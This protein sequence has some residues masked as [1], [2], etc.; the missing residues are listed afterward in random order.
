MR[1]QHFEQMGN[2]LTPSTK[3]SLRMRL[4]PVIDSTRLTLQIFGELQ[5]KEVGDETL[6][7][8][9]QQLAN[10]KGLKAACFRTQAQGAQPQ[11]AQQRGAP[12]A[13][14]PAAARLAQRPRVSA[15][16]APPPQSPPPLTRTPEVHARPPRLH[17]PGAPIDRDLCR[18][19]NGQH[20]YRDCPD[21][22][23][24]YRSG[25][26]VEPYRQPARCSPAFAAAATT[27]VTAAA[28]R[29]CFPVYFTR[30]ASARAHPGGRR[31]SY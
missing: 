23:L 16:G 1:E 19:H 21:R 11:S 14:Q 10:L 22:V 30:P 2:K 12:P 3:L 18:K 6:R 27:T 31:R 13:K 4:V 28:A 15:E 17:S 29:G 7:A 5:T 26:K 25:D 24:N 20:A 8:F 9:E